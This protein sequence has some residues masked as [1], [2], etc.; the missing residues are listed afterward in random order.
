MR[1][2]LAALEY[3]SSRDVDAGRSTRSIISRRREPPDVA[4]NSISRLGVAG[5]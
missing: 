1:G 4:A 3:R 2:Y 5:H